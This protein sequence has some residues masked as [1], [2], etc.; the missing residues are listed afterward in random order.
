MN[1]N[2]V[3]GQ[4]ID[5][6]IK[7]HRTLGPGMLESAY[8]ACLLFELHRRGLRAAN[9]VEMPIIYE[10]VKIDVGYRLDVVVE[11]AVIIEIK[12]VRELLPIHQAQLLSYLRVSDLRLGLLINFHELK[13]KDGIV[14]L[15]NKL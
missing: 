4:V 5:A 12:A 13:L 2:D 10:S 9:Q 3:S 14:R 7:V 6:A 15:V 1:I 11:Q 8:E